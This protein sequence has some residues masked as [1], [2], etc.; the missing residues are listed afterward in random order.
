VLPEALGT[1]YGTAKPRCDDILN[2][3][4]RLW[5]SK[6]E[7]VE[8]RTQRAMRGTFDRTV[9]TYKVSLKYTKLPAET[10]AS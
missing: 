5:L 6:G 3:H 2:P 8:H 4:Y 1:D 9:A 10:R 7:G